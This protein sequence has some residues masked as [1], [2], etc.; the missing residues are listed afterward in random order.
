MAVSTVSTNDVST[1]DS[2]DFSA[3][4]GSFRPVDVAL[5]GVS[6]EGAAGE[7]AM[8]SAGVDSGSALAGSE[9]AGT[10]ASGADGIASADFSAESADC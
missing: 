8:G 9:I 6:C 10:W 1:E 7:V 5:S 2:A 3:S 4:T